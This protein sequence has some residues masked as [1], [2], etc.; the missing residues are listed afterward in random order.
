[1]PKGLH[2]KEQISLGTKSEGYLF[3]QIDLRF[4]PGLI[5]FLKLVSYGSG[6][7]QQEWNGGS[8]NLVQFHE[9]TNISGKT[10]D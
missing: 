7:A 8:L 3:C 2:H 6:R 10:Y 1:M 5:P 4:V 9:C